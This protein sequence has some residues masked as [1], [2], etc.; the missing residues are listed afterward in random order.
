MVNHLE[1]GQR[2]MA[3]RME[4]VVPSGVVQAHGTK[5]VDLGAGSMFGGGGDE[6]GRLAGRGVTVP[7]TV[8]ALPCTP[9]VGQ[10]RSGYRVMGP[11]RPP[12]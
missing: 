9:T 2:P 3:D 6:G 5:V 10:R 8:T 11:N 4:V 12:P 7:A 1:E